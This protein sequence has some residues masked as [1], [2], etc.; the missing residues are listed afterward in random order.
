MAEEGT[1]VRVETITVADAGRLKDES[2]VL[3]DKAEALVIVT[4]EHHEAALVER[5]ALT[6]LRR[7]IVEHYNDSKKQASKLHKQIVADEKKLTA[8]IDAALRIIDRKADDYE[9]KV[10]RERREKERRLREEARK[11]EVDEKIDEAAQLEQ[12]GETAHAEHVLESPVEMPAISVPSKA[13]TVAGISKRKLYSA[14]VYDLMALLKHIVNEEPSHI[15][16]VQ[17]NTTALNGQ[18]RSLKE[19]MSLPGVRL[20]TGTS[21]TVRE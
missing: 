18:A 8:P 21:R 7:K 3:V 1:A 4:K 15:N 11:L 16:F 20:V 14:E 5:K 17:A 13:A 9:T 10:E 19:S 6:L 2:N 12:E